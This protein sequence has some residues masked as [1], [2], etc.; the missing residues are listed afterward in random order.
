MSRPPSPLFLSGPDE[1]EYD[2]DDSASNYELPGANLDPPGLRLAYLN[3]MSDHIVRKHPVEDAETSLRN[4]I[5]SVR[6][7]NGIPP[8][9][10]PLT[11]LKAV[12][13]HLGLNTSLLLTRRA[14]CSECYKLYTWEEVTAAELPAT[15][16]RTRPSRCTGT[17]MKLGWK[18]GK[19]TRMPA[20]IIVYSKIIP[21]LRR[22]LMRPSF[23]CLLSEGAA[24]SRRERAA[25][26]LYDVCD[27]TAWKS[28][29]IGLRRVFRRD[30][31]VVDEAITPGSDV[32][33]SNLGYGLFA[34]L[35]IDWFSVTKKRSC[36]AIYLAILNI[37]RHARYLVHNVILAC[38]IAGPKEPSLE[39][40]NFVLE[41]IVESFKKLYAGVIIRVYNKNLPAVVHPV[42]MYPLMV[43]ADVPARSKIQGI[44]PHNHAQRIGCDCEACQADINRVE[45]YD[46]T[47]FE[48]SD[49]FDIL[50][51]AKRATASPEARKQIARDYGI[52]WS[53]LNELPGWL[54][55]ASAPFD[56]MHCLYLGIVHSFWGDVIEDGHMLS[57]QQATLFEDFLGSLQWPSQIGRLPSPTTTALNRKKADEW[58]R[59]VSVLPL[60]LWVAW[61]T[62]A[63]TI[64]AGAPRIP[65]QTSKKPTFRRDC[66]TIWDCAVYLTLS[67]RLF[68]SWIAY[69]PDIDRAQTYMRHF[70]EGLLRLRVQLKPNH[71][72]AMHLPQYFRAFGP[73]YSW[74]LFPYERFNGLLEEVELNGHPD[75]AETSLARWWVRSHLLFDF[76]EHLPDDA[77]EEER[78]VLNQLCT[79]Y[80]NRGT[81]LTMTESVYGG[82]PALRPSKVPRRF[83]NLRALDRTGT[84]YSAILAFAQATWPQ[85]RLISD[86]D[87][88]NQN[89]TFFLSHK[90]AKQLQFVYRNS[91]RYGCASSSRT[92]ADQ[93][94]LMLVDGRRI[95]VRILWHFWLEVSTEEPKIC[96]VVARLN[97]TDVPL[98]PWDLHADDLGYF[99]AIDDHVDPIEVISPA[100][101]VSSVVTGT[102]VMRNN[103]Q[104]LRAVIGYDRVGHE[105]FENPGEGEGEDMDIGDE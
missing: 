86:L 58:R 73:C 29:R 17:Y 72:Y 16:T 23:L 14:V 87:F 46:Y 32:A 10:K 26:V 36:G 55:H 61:R 49:E 76:L 30:G 53:A 80:K 70:C 25:D 18:K 91:L 69:L 65:A 44:P 88:Q 31:T 105:I 85:L 98:L 63:D 13:R 64:P 37:A 77:T 15:C 67:L 68:T 33:V 19:L 84:L 34:A 45:G 79:S 97:M 50:A 60:G 99:V 51:I 89:G 56:P 59:L 20:K 90:V 103:G 7:S 62:D 39:N 66:V 6:L 48:F 104:R 2:S 12:R 54:P 41:P 11:T 5:N 52:R 96:S 75:D 42:Y 82:A 40:L 92:P 35:N 43:D 27:G 78:E 102:F 100:Q 4:T 83:S 101:L 57:S 47:K 9:I 95:P 28:A 3:A 74:W 8:H 81:L 22:M 21:S 94:A 1:I 24:L 93:Y 38:V 71:H